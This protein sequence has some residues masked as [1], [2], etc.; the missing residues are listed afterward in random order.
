MY[1][2]AEVLANIDRSLWTVVA[3]GAVLF[4]GAYGM[5]IEAIRLGFR[6][7]TH[8]I[9]LFA[10][11]YFFAHDIFFIALYDRWFHEVNHV[12]YKLF[13]VG[14]VIFTLLEVVVHYQALKYS[15]EELFPSLTQKQYVLAYVVMQVAVGVFF[16]F[17]FS[18]LDD[19]LYLVNFCATIVL[20]NAFNVPLLISRNSQ[21]GQSRLLTRATLMMVVGF[22]FLLAPQLSI[23]FATPVFWTLGLCTVALNLLYAHCLAR[24]PRYDPEAAPGHEGGVRLA[25]AASSAS[26]AAR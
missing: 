14:L 20:S 5:Y 22:F 13:W 6:D 23:Y 1:S 21:R 2:P 11:M 15:R 3:A 9:P 26:T 7:K 4:V 25:S 12:L 16:W 17:V 18:Q 19:Y 8:A 24:Y 10:N